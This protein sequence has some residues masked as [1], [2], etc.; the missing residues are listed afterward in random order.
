MVEGKE[1]VPPV[2]GR[3]WIGGRP[4]KEWVTCG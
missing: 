2:S 3:G 4:S 1:S